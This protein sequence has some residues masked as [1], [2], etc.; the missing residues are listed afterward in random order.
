MGPLKELRRPPSLV[1]EL[2]GTRLT[3][4]DQLNEVLHRLLQAD[5]VEN[6]RFEVPVLE[7]A[8]QAD[9]D[10]RLPGHVPLDAPLSLRRLENGPNTANV[11]AE[12]PLWLACVVSMCL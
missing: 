3:V 8:N 10:H 11:S 12:A 1:R 2:G 7:G 5:S 6:H 4:S 9:S